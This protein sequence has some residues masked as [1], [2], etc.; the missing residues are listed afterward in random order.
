VVGAIVWNNNIGPN[1]AYLFDP[2]DYATETFWGNGGMTSADVFGWAAM[3]FTVAGVAL[4]GGPHR[5]HRLAGFLVV[6]L[7]NC[8]MGVAAWL[9]AQWYLLALMVVLNLLNVRGAWNNWG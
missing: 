9:A 1:Q 7:G 5:S 6:F 8:Y 2:M 4:L 3:G